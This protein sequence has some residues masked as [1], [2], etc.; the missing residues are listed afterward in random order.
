MKEEWKQLGEDFEAL[1]EDVKTLLAATSELSDEKII[2]ARARLISSM[3]RT[4][5]AAEER[6][7][8][9]RHYVRKHPCE[10]AIIAGVVGIV[11]ALL[12]CQRCECR[13]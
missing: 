3:E 6:A 1:K 13:R 7:K 8:Q 12:I 4:R 9:A 2:N 5:E 11:A 10:T